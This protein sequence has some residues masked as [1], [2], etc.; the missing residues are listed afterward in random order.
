MPETVS[1]DHYEVLTRDDGSL[2]E[3]GRGAM[4]VTYKAFDTNLRVPVALKVINPAFLNSEIARQRFVREARSAA[5]LRHR[6]VA[7]VYHL[8]TESDAWFYAMEFIDGETVDALIKRHGPLE[9]VLALQVAAQVARALNAALPHGLV[10]RDLKPANLM[11]VR[12]DDDL[13]VKVID[14]G[15]AKSSLPDDAEEDAPGAGGFVGTPHFASPEQLEDHDIDVRSDLYSLGVTLWFMLA[16]RT[17]FVGTVEQVKQQHLKATPPFE[18]F[19]ALPAPVVAILRKALEK[20]AAKRQQTPQEFRR[21]IEE[22]LEQISGTTA[23]PPGEED[24]N[25][26]ALLEDAQER[27]GETQFEPRAIIAGRYRIAETLGE[28]NSGRVFRCYDR[29]RQR[30]VRMLVLN[31]DLVADRNAYTLVEREVER[32]VAVHHENLLEVSDFAA[33]DGASFLILEWTDGFSVLELLRARRELGASETLLLLKQAAAGVDRA[34]A[35]GLKRLDFAL[36]Q[37]F[38]HFAQT[39]DKEKL[40]RA[41]LATWPAFTLKLNP[42]GIT[43]ELSASETW[44]GGQTIVNPVGSSGEGTDARSRYVSALGAFAYELLGG[45]LSPLH[46][47][48]ATTTPT[49]SHYT[50]LSTLSEEGN[51]VLK[52]ALDPAQSFA[53]AQE[54]FA[55]LKDIEVLEIKRTEPVSPLP[56]GRPAAHASTDAARQSRAGATQ[57]PPS[58]RKR[59]KVPMAFFRGLLTVVAIGAGIYFLSPRENASRGRASPDLP[60]SPESTEPPDVAPAPGD[61]PPM[62][63]DSPATPPREPAPPPK[64]EEKPLPEVD[65]AAQTREAKIREANEKAYA[66]ET[67]GDSVKAIETWLQVAREFPESDTPKKRLNVIIDPLRKRPELKKPEAFDAIKPLLVEAAQLDCLSAVLMLAEAERERDHK[68]SF[69]WYSI[70]AEKGRTEAYLQMGLLLSNGLDQGP[71]LEKGFQYF[72]LA[73]ESNDVDAKTALAECYLLGKG[74]GAP[75]DYK[76]GIKWLK[77]AADEGNL[78]AMNRLADGYD[79]NRFEL[80]V[81]YDEAFRLW[82]KVAETKDPTGQ[83][84]QP[85]GEATGNLGVLY[86]NG[87]GTTQDEVRAVT[88]FKE[89][90][91]LGD[92]NSMYFLGVCRQLGRGGLVKNASDG[93]AQIKKAAEAGSKPAQNWCLT[94]GVPYR[95]P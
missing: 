33:V 20:D 80:P 12:E 67:A 51:E 26:A 44:A 85:I 93:Q 81:N 1:F 14:F 87:H 32:I 35:T 15:L 56:A 92:P 2:Y 90:V 88:L 59:K 60:R 18:Q 39:I 83:H 65:A 21:A 84:R 54:F 43:R 41:P 63:V 36:H 24:E 52:R 71:E 10:H 42:L 5:K 16:G 45:T 69:G 62:V 76:N 64:A 49:S 79:H 61:T 77:E 4:G 9:P 29:E 8:G 94:N 53:S 38:V 50:P 34:L 3:L 25:L 11:L 86:M 27:P 31:P 78:R 46:L 28:T 19:T 91:R 47:A 48:G 17:P 57:S 40:L 23:Q 89:G 75:P 72:R 7:T 13:V 68:A 58:P 6:N 66:I 37:I 70:A 73:A 95:A 74:T 55:A 82:S 30:D 22:C